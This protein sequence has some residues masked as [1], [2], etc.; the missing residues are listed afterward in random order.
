MFL[1]LSTPGHRARLISSRCRY[2][3]VVLYFC[4]D[5]HLE[6]G[7]MLSNRPH[8]FATVFAA[9]NPVNSLAVCACRSR[10]ARSP[11]SLFLLALL[12]PPLQ[13][14]HQRQ[15]VHGPGPSR[16]Q[17]GGQA[18]EAGGR[19]GDNDN[20]RR[21]RGRAVGGSKCSSTDRGEGGGRKERDCS[22]RT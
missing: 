17:A 3:S 1:V 12:S 21:W 22:Q 8:Y 10:R 20:F 19:I 14:R 2:P 18:R 15:Q 13:H 5:A 6:P 9:L 16:R 11:S 4:Q 7:H